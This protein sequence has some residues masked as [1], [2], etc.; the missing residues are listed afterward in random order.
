M[1]K[2]LHNNRGIILHDELGNEAVTQIQLMNGQEGVMVSHAWDLL[3]RK[4]RVEIFDSE[5][6]GVAAAYN[7]REI[8]VRR[9]E[10]RD[11]VVLSWKRSMMNVYN[12]VSKLPTS[13][14]QQLGAC[15]RLVKV[16]EEDEKG[17]LSVE[18]RAQELSGLT[19]SQEEVS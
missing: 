17:N 6:G 10:G 1:K 4:S 7:V 14:S 18:Q 2:I 12:L 19:Y 15:A 9:L 5:G 11:L 13:P 8:S 3:S 16:E